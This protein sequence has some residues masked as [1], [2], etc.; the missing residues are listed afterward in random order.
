MYSTFDSGGI[1]PAQRESAS[2]WSVAGSPSRR[3]HSTRG[4]PRQHI[5]LG[6]RQWQRGHRENVQE[7]WRI[8]QVGELGADV[9]AGPGNEVSCPPPN[10]DDTDRHRL[11]WIKA[12][13][14][15]FMFEF[16]PPHRPRSAVMWM[17]PMRLT[18]LRR[19]SREF[20]RLATLC[21]KVAEHRGNL[22]CVRPTG[23]PAAVDRA[24]S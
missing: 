18:G 1:M 7:P 2:Q 13:V 23:D 22:R 9:Q 5:H 24:G 3:S 19:S 17:I 6:S 4:K 16:N 8:A 21:G 10:G 14:A 20:Q 15:R 11:A 12:A